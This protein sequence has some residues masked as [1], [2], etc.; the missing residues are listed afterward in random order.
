MSANSTKT[1]ISN[2]Q[3]LLLPL[4]H[5]IGLIS[6]NNAEA[7]N[8]SIMYLNALEEQLGPH[9]MTGTTNDTFSKKLFLEYENKP[10]GLK[11]PISV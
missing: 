9:V 4:V 1:P 3:T 8:D 10:Y 11:N 2:I 6:E 7:K 5:T